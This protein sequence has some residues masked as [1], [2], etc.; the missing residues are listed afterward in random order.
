MSN[1]EKVG[2][3]WWG[4]GKKKP[5]GLVA[6]SSAGK[7]SAAEIPPPPPPTGSQQPRRKVVVAGGAVDVVGGGGGGGGGIASLSGSFRKTVKT[8]NA[9]RAVGSARN[10]FAPSSASSSVSSSPYAGLKPA[11]PGG[12]G[13]TGVV[14]AGSSASKTK[15]GCAAP[16]PRA[17][18]KATRAPVGG[19]GFG[20]LG[21]ANIVPTPLVAA[22]AAPAVPAAPAAQARAWGGQ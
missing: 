17:T 10:V 20:T 22:S 1:V 2:E 15:L 21:A 3:G 19:T 18:I 4:G 11:L 7:K 5:V 9:R 13:R 6:Y 12:A 8:T 14:S 16:F